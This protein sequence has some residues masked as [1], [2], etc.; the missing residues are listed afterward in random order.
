MNNQYTLLYAAAW[1]VAAIGVVA[2]VLAAY[3]HFVDVPPSW[4]TPDVVRT[5]AVLVPICAGLAALLPRVTLTPAKR[6]AKYLAAMAG[7]L[8]RDIARKYPTVLVKGAT[9]P[10]V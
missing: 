1:V 6:D 2:G 3:W 10:E 9:P 7:V 8:P 5:C 4:L